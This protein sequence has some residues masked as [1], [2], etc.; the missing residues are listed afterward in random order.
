MSM[1]WNLT[2][3][4]LKFA[5]EYCIALDTITAE[6]TM[7]LCDFKLLSIERKNEKVQNSSGM[8]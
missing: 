1:Q 8:F 7:K 2:F 3:D 4:M 5:I 6:C